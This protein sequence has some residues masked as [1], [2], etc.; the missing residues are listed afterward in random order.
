MK[1]SLGIRPGHW[2]LHL[3]PTT[4]PDTLCFAAA[5]PAEYPSLIVLDFGMQT[6]PSI[7]AQAQHKRIGMNIPREYTWCSE[8][9]RIIRH[10]PGGKTPILVF[11][12]L[13]PFYDEAVEIQERKFLLRHLLF[14]LKRL[15]RSTKLAVIVPSPPPS[16]D[17]YCLL[18]GLVASASR[19]VPY[20]SHP[21]DTRDMKLF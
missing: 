3:L 20:P 10:L 14:H 2:S 7:G 5:K 16:Y 9:V 21:S 15:G 8:A 4:S 13:A 18:G 1:K 11:D 6:I 17:A 19:V 12:I